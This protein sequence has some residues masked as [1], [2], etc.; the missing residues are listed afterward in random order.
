M[1]RKLFPDAP[2]HED[3]EGP[4]GIRSRL[5]YY[6]EEEELANSIT[7]AIGVVFSVVALVVLIM[8]AASYGDP[9]RVTS[10]AIYGVCMLTFYS[11]STVYHTVR[12]PYAR[13]IFRILDHVSI[14]FMIAGSY[15]PF[16]L[17]TLRGPWG[18]ALFITVWV[19]ALL[20]AVLKVFT[21]HR[22]P[23]LGP[24]LY[25]VMGWIVVVALKPL[26]AALAPTGLKL[27]F[28]GG[29]AYT[30]GVIFYAWEKLPYNH[31]IWHVIVLVGSICH[32]LS[33]FY[34]VTPL[35]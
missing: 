16:T 9:Y 13:Y 32:F 17:V 31:A 1:T 14:Y 8:R 12:K 35:R 29:L 11:L 24:I 6:T 21:T 4:E 28:A 34:Y 30:L 10:V 33:I 22:H 25:I 20:G 2:E 15:T 18:W 5:V 23:I 19:A 26:S 27:L 7:H 3:L